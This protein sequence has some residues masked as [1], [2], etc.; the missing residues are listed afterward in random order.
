MAVD[1]RI[2]D[3]TLNRAQSRVLARSHP[4]PHF[5]M[6]DLF[7][8]ASPT[9][10]YAVMGNP[11]AH[12][13][14]PQIHRMFAEQCA[15][16]LRYERIQVD[17]GGFEQA[18]NNF[19]AAGGQ[20]LNVTVPFKVNAWQ[21]A[22]L[23]S[24]R[25]ER[26]EAVNTLQFQAT[27]GCFGDNTDGVGLLRDLVR[28]LGAP[29][30]GAT[31]LILGAG[32]AVRGILEP[33]LGAGPRHLVLANRTVDR[34]VSLA[35]H[36]ADLGTVEACGF[37]KLHGRRFDLIIN[38]TAAS[39]DD[40]MPPLPR[41]CF[42]SKAVAYDLMYADRPTV[43]MRW[44]ADHGAAR[45]VDGLGMLIEQAAES[46]L[47][48]HGVRPDTVPVIAALRPDPQNDPHQIKRL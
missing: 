20:G 22:E 39:L 5:E 36:F 19:Q 21:L 9:P 43:F 18:L 7:D 40:Q 33:L 47:I 24:P 32:G 2:Q 26:A 42:A 28:N 11:V 12:S 13:K 10:R 6:T 4:L 29:L 23:R 48:W 15:I 3:D 25:A 14:S 1:C 8:F 34:A 38:A 27:G 17:P 31:V 16:A 44:A 45:A 35:S 37:D 41:D 30:A 46:F